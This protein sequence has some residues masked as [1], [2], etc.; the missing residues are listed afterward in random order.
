M[1]QEILTEL[2]WIAG[3]THICFTSTDP[4][5][6]SVDAIVEEQD[7]AMVLGPAPLL[8]YSVENLPTLINRMETQQ[9]S[10]P[11]D[12][13]IKKTN[14][15]RRFIAVVYDID[16]TPICQWDWVELALHTIFEQCELL[17]IPTLAMPLP[18]HLHGKLDPETTMS[19]LQKILRERRASYPKKILIYKL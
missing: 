18:G 10:L 11:G 2:D 17:K 16:Q 9:Q 1:L 3:K 15:P 6:L 13:I 5:L 12:V 7:T 4:A 8:K 19:Q 14:F